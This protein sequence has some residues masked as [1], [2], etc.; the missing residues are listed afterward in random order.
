MLYVYLSCIK[1][2]KN[3]EANIEIKLLQIKIDLFVRCK[4]RRKERKNK[5]I[6]SLHY[7]SSLK[8]QG[9]IGKLANTSSKE[10]EM[11]LCVCVCV[12]SPPTF[13]LTTTLNGRRSLFE[14]GEEKKRFPR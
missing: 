1:P 11:N 2:K 6:P 3:E 8:T 7:C 4:E 12:V 5:V 13:S 9:H 10:H 14:S